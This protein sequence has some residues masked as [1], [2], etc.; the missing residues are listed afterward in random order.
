MLD[1]EGK[2]QW[3]E[4][5]IAVVDARVFRGNFYDSFVTRMRGRLWEMKKSAE[6]QKGVHDDPD[7]STALALRDKKKDVEEAHQAQRAQVKHLREW[8][9]SDDTGRHSDYTGTAQRAGSQ[10]AE[11]VPVGETGRGVKK[12][13]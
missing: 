4:K 1:D 11:R 13:K 7:S 3:E 2:E 10:A 9:S 6:R 12:A 8:K 5:E